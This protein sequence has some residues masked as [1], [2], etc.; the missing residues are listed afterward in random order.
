MGQD[1]YKLLGVDRN[2]SEDDIKKAYKKMALKWHPDRNK[3]S[4]DASA[5]F[6][7]ISEAFEVLS[8]KQKRTIYDQFGEEGLKGGGGPPP[9]AGAGGFPG[10]G[11]SGFP[12]GG[13][14]QT[15]TF[16][17]G[18]G[19]FGSSGGGRGGFSPGDPFSIFEQFMGG[20]G[21]M[22][23]GGMGG[24]RSSMFTT[25]DD[26]VP[27]SF[28]T[29]RSGGMPG[30][31]SSGGRPRPQR[32]P[33]SPPPQSA[34]PSEI[35]KPLKV[36]LDDLYNGATKHL[37]VG[38]KLLGGGTE[39]KVLEIQVLP[40]WKEGTKIRF[41]RAG[42]EQ[43]TGESQDLVF[44]VEEKPHDRFTREGNDLVCK[45][46]IPLV[47]A[48]TGGSSKKTIEAL[49]GRKLQ[50]TVPSGVVKPGQETRIAGEG[51]PIRKAGKKGD[52]I[53]RWDVVFPDRLT[54]AQK[55]GNASGGRLSEA[56]LD[57]LFGPGDEARRT[58]IDA[59]LDAGRT[60]MR[61]TVSASGSTPTVKDVL[62]RRLNYNVPALR[63]LPEAFTFLS[64]PPT[65]LLNL[66]L[67]PLDPTP[68]LSH[69]FKVADE[70]CHIT[71]D[72]ATG[73]EWYARR[74]TLAAVY[75]AAELHQLTSPHGTNE[76]LDSLLTSSSRLHNTVTDIG[77]FANYLMPDD[78]IREKCGGFTLKSSNL[79]VL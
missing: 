61:S 55:E 76:L 47:E 51:M 5:K 68:A 24:G 69:A 35:T 45:V 26:D 10:G 67:P 30:G 57:A 60:E 34:G 3:G 17:S 74:A 48:L 7:Q 78:A 25:D 27:G 71:H 53:V 15:F 77:E 54:E 72:P 13:G 6:K 70:A 12:G 21:G 50:V 20:M 16:T 73:T 79:L 49:D 42:N 64:T 36:S 8:D 37:K 65:P 11:F 18:P 38:R 4:E 39:D 59:W 63:Y 9:G 41:P 32:R 23:G 31:F 29:S 2:A 62:E 52:L 66:R 1:Y 46:K 33:S 14:A 40:G 19:G 22:G 56:A 28:F 44:V 75:S 43:P 58:L